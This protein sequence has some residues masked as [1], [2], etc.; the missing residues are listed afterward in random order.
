MGDTELGNRK[1]KISLLGVLLTAIVLIYILFMYLDIFNVKIS[2]SSSILKYISIILC[3]MMTL[4]IG[5][6]GFNRRDKLLLQTGLFITV[7][8]DLCFLILD[9]YI[10]G[11]A[12]FCLVQIIYYNRYRGGTMHEPPLIFTRFIIIFISVIVVY[13]IINLMFTRIN[14]IFAIAFF[15]AICLIYSTAESIKAFKNNLYPCYNK[16]I[17]VMGMILFLLCDVSIAIFNTSR[18][19]DIFIHNVSA[20]SIWTFYLPS[21]ALLSISGYRFEINKNMRK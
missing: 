19:F 6:G 17:I 7:L 15:Y 4:F 9:Y 5:E 10:L 16:Y 20:L 18:E 3:F 12:L 13:I 11:I 2:V 14:L 21:Q 8:A 1:L